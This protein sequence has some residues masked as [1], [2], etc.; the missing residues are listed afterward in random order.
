MTLPQAPPRLASLAW[1]PFLPTCNSS[2]TLCQVT[3]HEAL[4]HSPTH[5]LPGSARCDILASSLTAYPQAFLK[6]A[7]R[8]LHPRLPVLCTPSGL[9]SH[10]LSLRAPSPPDIHTLCSQQLQG[11]H[12]LT[13]HPGGESLPHFAKGWSLRATFIRCSMLTAFHRL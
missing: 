1:H 5:T 11:Y 10:L 13:S 6:W 9:A 7:P 8:T 12:L 4:G 3:L 2:H